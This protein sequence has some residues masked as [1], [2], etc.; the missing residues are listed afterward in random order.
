[1]NPTDWPK[2]EEVFLDAAALPRAERNAFLDE[3]C[4]SHL[5]AEVDS[6]LEADDRAGLGFLTD[7]P[8]R[9]A[10][11][12]IS[13]HP[14]Q[15]EPGETIAN[16]RVLNLVTVGGMG[17]VYRVEHE[18]TGQ[19]MALKV[20]RRHMLVDPAAAGRFEREAHAAQ[21]LAH[22]NIVQVFEFSDS[23]DGMFMAMEWVDGETWRKRIDASR[24]APAEALQWS[25][26][27][28]GAIAAAHEAG[29]VHRDIKPDNIMV[30]PAG[31]VKVLDFGLARL[32]GYVM[33]E[34]EAIG[35]NGTISGTLSG[36]LPY[37]SPEILMGDNAT[38]ASD[39]FSLGSVLYE[40]FTG[41][42]PFA[43]ETP[44]DIFEA[45]ECRTPAPPSQLTPELPSALDAV[46]LA[47][48]DRDPTRRP[49]AATARKQLCAISL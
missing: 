43:G 4:P 32:A 31:Q 49:S 8:S 39:V 18:P 44:L 22:P 38:Y 13:R 23:D 1:M 30:T 46:L 17:E 16:Y 40:L 20:L 12:L 29:V 37:M 14:N 45:L 26:Q 10:A 41:H 33:P 6:L 27:V 24:P 25:C 5:R 34:V 36:T 3:N 28:A 11:D 2:I 48:L 7:L 35:S 9:L 47:L 15:M 19:T 21:A 42:H